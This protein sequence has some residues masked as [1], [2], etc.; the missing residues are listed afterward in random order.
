MAKFNYIITIHNKESILEKTLLGVDACCSKDSVIYPVLDGC[1][2]K[3]EE[4]VNNF[5]KKTK[6]T[7]IIIKTPD[8]HEIKSINAALRQIKEGFTIC[9][10]D[11][12][13]LQEPDLEEKIKKLYQEEGP[14]LGVVSFC[15]A[16]NLRQTP[17]LKQIRQS[18]FKPLVEECDLIKVKNDPCYGGQI[19]EDDKLV[20]RMVA[21][22]SPVCIPEIVLK[23]VGIL[24]KNMAPYSFDDHEYCIRAMKAGFRNGLFP[25]RFTSKLEWGGTRN[26]K[27]FLKLAGYIHLRNRRYIWKKHGQFIKKYWNNK[28]FKRSTDLDSKNGICL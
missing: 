6:R 11:D 26:D 20:Y 8:V 17:L 24:D 19:V 25:L 23:R 5:V 10:Q 2:D 4:I 27:N 12:V 9:L 1:T 15:R 3:S 21:I 14:Q 22:K 16:A 13:I 7:V 18:G 28:H